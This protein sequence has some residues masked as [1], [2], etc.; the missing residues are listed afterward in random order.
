M[1]T[2]VLVDFIDNKRDNFISREQYKIQ[3]SEEA[4]A[5]MTKEQ[6]QTLRENLGKKFSAHQS[7]LNE[8]LKEISKTC[9]E[10]AS[11]P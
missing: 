5:D 11:D 2:N 9:F 6:K 10:Y 3:T 1:E 7:A 4:S 8:V